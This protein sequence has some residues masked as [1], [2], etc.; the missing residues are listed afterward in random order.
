MT[1]SEN[2]K[3]ARLR[4]DFLVAHF[5]KK[6]LAYIKLCDKDEDDV[7]SFSQEPYT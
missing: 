2:C 5:D 4:K 6:M 3:G 1:D 7:E